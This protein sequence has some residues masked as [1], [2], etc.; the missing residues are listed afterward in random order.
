M[1]TILFSMCIKFFC[2]IINNVKTNVT[3]DMVYHRDLHVI[4]KISLD[5]NLCPYKEKLNVVCRLQSN[6]RFC[7]CT[8]TR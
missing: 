1:Q 7:M 2:L 8:S 6:L 5:K 4:L 3:H